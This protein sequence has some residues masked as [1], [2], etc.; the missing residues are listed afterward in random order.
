[1][2]TKAWAF[3][4]LSLC[5][6]PEMCVST[7]ASSVIL[8]IC[9]YRMCNC[10]IYLI[11]LT[12]VPWYRSLCLVYVSYPFLFLSCCSFHFH[13]SQLASRAIDQK[14]IH[15]SLNLIIHAG[16]AKGG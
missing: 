14:L 12:P 5:S 7:S 1:M 16:G 9:Y 10:L 3:V 8:L 13:S 6:K 4:G 2:E 15:S 11:S